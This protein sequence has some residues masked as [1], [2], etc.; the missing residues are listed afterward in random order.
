MSPANE[1]IQIVDENNIEIAAVSRKLMREQ[2]LIHRASYVLVFNK[3]GDLFIQR[4][5]MSKDIYPGYWD[6]AAGGV[7]LAN[8]SYDD[9]ARRELQEE[10]GICGNHFLTPCFDH[11]YE[12]ADNRV[13]GRVYRCAHEGPF[14]LQPEEVEYGMFVPVPTALRMSGQEPFTPDGLE[15]LNRFGQGCL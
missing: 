1:I 7:V 14:T 15:I 4:R 5:T 2:N 10:L 3:T 13:W 8:E 12:D 9:S 11:F 6:I